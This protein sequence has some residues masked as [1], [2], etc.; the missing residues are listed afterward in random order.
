MASGVVT[1]SL[2]GEERILTDT[3]SRSSTDFEGAS[4]SEEAY[5]S[6]EASYSS[7]ATAPATSVHSVASD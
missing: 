6:K 1:T 4:G 2:S 5:R 7:G 3:P